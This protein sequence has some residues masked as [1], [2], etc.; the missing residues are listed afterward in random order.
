MRTTV[1]LGISA[2]Y[3]HLEF[4]IHTLYSIIINNIKFVYQEPTRI[5]TIVVKL[6]PNL[7]L[8]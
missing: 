7:V 4:Q 6:F 8:R 1:S 2:Y 3:A 5:Q